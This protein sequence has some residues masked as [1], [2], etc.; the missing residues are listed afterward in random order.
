MAIA[1]EIGLGV[2]AALVLW[3]YFG[4]LA[5]LIVVALGFAA[6]YIAVHPGA[7]APILAWCST[8]LSGRSCLNV[9][10][11]MSW[12]GRTFDAILQW[13]GTIHG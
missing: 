12:S 11:A 8:W 13:M 5:K 7:S 3:Q 4:R 10:T 2:L 6:L 1:I 9:Q